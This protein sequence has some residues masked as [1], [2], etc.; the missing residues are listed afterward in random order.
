[1]ALLGETFRAGAWG[2]PIAAAASLVA[3]RGVVLLTKGGAPVAETAPAASTVVA[4][5]RPVPQPRVTDLP[6]PHPSPLPASTA[7]PLPVPEVE[8]AR[9]SLSG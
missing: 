8:A 5:S 7:L 6:A 3:A 4:G 1:M 2:W 9:A